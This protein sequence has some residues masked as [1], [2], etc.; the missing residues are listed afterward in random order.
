MIHR[1]DRLDRYERRAF[2]QR[3]RALNAIMAI[4][5]RRIKHEANFEFCRQARNQNFA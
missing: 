4:S 5:R 2:A 3:D 1:P